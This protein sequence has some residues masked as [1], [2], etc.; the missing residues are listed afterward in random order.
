MRERKKNKELKATIR[1]FE[2]GLL[3]LQPASKKIKMEDQGLITAVPV[4]EKDPTAPEK[5]TMASPQVKARVITGLP[6]DKVITSA[7]T[8]SS[9]HQRN[10]DIV[11]KKHSE[12]VMLTELEKE[13]LATSVQVLDDGRN[14]L[15]TASRAEITRALDLWKN[16]LI[17][18][19][20]YIPH[21]QRS[22]ERQLE[23][24]RVLKGAM[25]DYTRF[26]PA[27]PQAITFQHP[28]FGPL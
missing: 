5:T 18:S 28:K 23:R 1:D 27:G 11:L 6:G 17:R 3:G 2:E 15:R 8:Q 13:E 4:K 20:E 16:Y 26:N 7:Y 19:D 9:H 24:I 10:L 21:Q 14:S 25:S 12:D 22:E